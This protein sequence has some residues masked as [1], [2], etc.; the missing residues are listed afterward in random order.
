VP[1]LSGSELAEWVATVDLTD[2]LLRHFASELRDLE[3]AGADPRWAM[4]VLLRHAA[5]LEAEAA[6]DVRTFEL[7]AA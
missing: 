4:I 1:F 2:P 3:A 6:A 5:N 7:V